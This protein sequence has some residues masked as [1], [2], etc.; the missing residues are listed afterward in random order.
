MYSHWIALLCVFVAGVGG[1]SFFALGYI[2]LA[3]WM[4]WQGNNLYVMSRRTYQV[5]QIV[6]HNA[7]SL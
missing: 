5:S 4:L 1:T 2:V 3:F 6:V 7:I